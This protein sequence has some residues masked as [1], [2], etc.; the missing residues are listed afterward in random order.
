MA[1][2][3]NRSSVL[4]IVEETV[5][6]TIELPSVGTEMIA[7]QEGFEFAPNFNVL[8]NAE[9]RSS[10]GAS[11]PIQGL[12]SP[13]GSFDHYLRHS[14]VEGQAP[15]YKVLLKSIF[16]TQTVN[17]T[18]RLTA[19][20][21]TVSLL[22][23]AAGG[24]DFARGKAVLVKD[25]TN[26]YAIR[27]VDSV[28][29]ND[30]TLGFD[31]LA[32]PAAGLGVGKCVNYAPADSGHAKFS[33]WLYRG[34]GGAV[35]VISGSQVTEMGI[36]VKAGELI[37]ASY[38]FEGVK[39]HFDPITITA[40]DTKLDFTDDD[41]TFVATVAAGT[42]RDPLELA[43]ALQDAM[44][45]ANSGETHTVVY[46]SA[47]GKFKITSTGTVL[48]LLWNTG[49]NA[50]NTIGDKIGFLT[51]ADDTGVAATTGYTSDN[52]QS[53]A[54]AITPSYDVAD[55][56]A[57]KNN[58]VFLGNSTDVS[59]FCASS[60]DFK[61]TNEIQDVLCVCALSGVQ[62][63]LITKRLVSCDIV[64]LLERYEAEK[65]KKYRNNDDVKFLFNFGIK[66]GG[67]WVAGKCGCI[68]VP[69][70][71]LSSFKLGDD[72]GIV[73]MELTI[74][75]YVDSSGNG[76]VYLNFL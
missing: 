4:A 42:Y 50:A 23:L 58:E 34:N 72:N 54:N 3:K 7:L 14:G 48:S 74:Q 43:Q 53:Y 60:L 61:I 76:E 51:A 27:P 2:E 46:L 38:S 69:S 36:S 5:P 32:A 55:P 24:G 47:S 28:A 73:T 68:Y 26:G 25:G 66:S 9:I 16:G 56:L 6:G 10:I 52:A 13:N 11:K 67:N 64:G 33:G 45:S 21:S 75:A 65:F 39:Y 22:K 37:V 15:G 41:G 57:A 59:C 71:T 1:A 49:G 8:E 40:T 35:E 20:A 12:E 19:A 29:T 44:N 62:E 70:A 18:E 31:L 17:A 30:L 63:K